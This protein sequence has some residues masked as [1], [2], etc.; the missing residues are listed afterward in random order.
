MVDVRDSDG[1]FE[2]LDGFL[3]VTVEREDE[4]LAFDRE[5]GRRGRE[6]KM[7]SS[8]GRGVGLIPFLL[9]GMNSELYRTSGSMMI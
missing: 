4:E 2:V 9:P 7:I 5:E 3:C 1:I 6:G 8:V